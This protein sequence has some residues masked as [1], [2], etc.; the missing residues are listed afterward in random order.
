M[1]VRQERNDLSG[2]DTGKRLALFGCL[3]SGSCILGYGVI[4]AGSG[5]T[6]QTVAIGSAALLILAGVVSFVLELPVMGLVRFGFVIS[7]FFKGDVTLFKIDAIEDPSGL[8][9]SLTLVFA[10]ILLTYDHFADDDRGMIFSNTF[11]FLLTAIF[12]CASVS[13]IYSG[14]TPLGGFS[15]VSLLSSIVIAYAVA[16]HFS[17]RERMVALVCGIA[18][19]LLFTGIAAISQ[20]VFDFPGDLPNIGTGT[21]DELLGTQSQLL[22]RVPAFLRTPTEMAWVVSS[23]VPILVAVAVSRLKSIESSHRILFVA[24]AFAGTAAVILSLARGS[25]LA[26]VIT[27]TIILSSAYFKL[28][29]DERKPYLLSLLGLTVLATVLLIPFSPRIYDRLTADDGGSAEI[30]VPLMETA[31]RMIDDN[32]ITGVGLNAYRA[33][34]TKYDETPNFTSQDFPN[35]VHNVFAHITAEIGIPGGLLYCL[36]ILVAL[37]ECFKTFGTHDRLLAALALGLGVGMIAFVISAIKEPGSLGSVR[38]PM[39]TCFLMFGM[40][41]AISRMPRSLKI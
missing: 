41:F 18:V 13:V 9:I 28:S 1:E 14:P 31:L 33:G 5:S 19:G 38:P 37:F 26:M 39:R 6:A 34:M 11:W 4:A 21:E 12:I 8:N 29:A 32:P 16:S 7:F 35:P 20:Y 2:F 27:I 17:V 36:L 15:L 23:L 22:S 24:A 40:I 10:L 25:W 30:R 3:L